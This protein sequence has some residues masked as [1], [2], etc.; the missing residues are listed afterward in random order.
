MFIFEVN[1]VM[2]VRMG[3]RTEGNGKFNQANQINAY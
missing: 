1:F 3:K 2:S